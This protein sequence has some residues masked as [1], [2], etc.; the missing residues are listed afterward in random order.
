MN[1]LQLANAFHE[2]ADH[3]VDEVTVPLGAMC[4][5]AASY[6]GLLHP[7]LVVSAPRDEREITPADSSIA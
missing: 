7:E 3:I 4:C 5:G 1:Y 2:V 6:R